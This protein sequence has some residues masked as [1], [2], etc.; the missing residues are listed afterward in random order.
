MLEAYAGRNVKHV[1]LSRNGWSETQVR[2]LLSAISCE[3]ESSRF[4]NLASID[5]SE[6]VFEAIPSTLLDEVG[7]FP[8]L[9]YID[10]GTNQVKDI[11]AML[12]SRMVDSDDFRVDLN[13]NPVTTIAAASTRLGSKS[14]EEF[15]RW[16]GTLVNMSRI[17]SFNIANC[18]MRG[19]IVSNALLMMPLLE[20]MA[21]LSN[22]LGGTLPSEIGLLTQLT[23]LDL[24][25]GFITGSMPSQ[26]GRLTRLN[27]LNLNSNAFTGPILPA[28]PTDPT[29]LAETQ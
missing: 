14:F 17:R 15:V 27:I 13:R 8:S 4:C 7:A 26:L 12:I 19:N 29:D 2:P 6:N 1:D 3:R 21:L 11:T 24:I 25:N 10:I 22:P 9:S 18:S 5:L 20:T 23:R 28:G 16:A